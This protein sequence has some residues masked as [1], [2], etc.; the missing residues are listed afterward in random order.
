MTLR[1][2]YHLSFLPLFLGFAA[3]AIGLGYYVV[4]REVAWGLAQESEGYALTLAGFIAHEP[5]TEPALELPRKRNL[6]T[7][8]SHSSGG[9]TVQWF[10][11][12]DTAWSGQML[13][14]TPGLNAP[15]SP[16]GSVLEA[17][18]RGEP[19]AARVRRSDA[20]YD[21]AVGYAP[22]TRADGT[23]RAVIGVTAKDAVT[24]AELR[25]LW[26]SSGWLAAA[27]VLAS[28]VVAEMLTRRAGRDI[29]ALAEGADA[30]AGGDYAHPWRGSIVKE[31]DDLAVTLRAIGRIL[32]D[33]VRQMR[34]HFLR[35]EQLPSDDD[36]ADACE[37]IRA[38]GPAPAGAPQVAV[39]T[40]GAGVPDDFWK[41]HRTDSGWHLVAGRVEAPQPLPPRIER[42]LRAHA[43][44]DLFCGLLKEHSPAEAWR[45]LDSAFTL[46]RGTSSSLL[47]NAELLTVDAERR[48]RMVT[49]GTVDESSLFAVGTLEPGAMRF[50]RDYLKNSRST[51]LTRVADELASL[52]AERG[53]GLLVVF[54]AP[55]C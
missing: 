35:S 19:A 40:I 46:E 7:L 22:L 21:E 2:R 25:S 13:V 53:R 17:L 24:R 4:N 42:T 1:L 12:G 44:A 28:L 47:A 37:A 5:P 16:D 23:L 38:S 8:L 43:A 49:G 45:E 50:A 48:D 27:A 55:R 3:A 52:L 6:A 31:L 41:I 10:E 30:L 26:W 32:G 20:S 33:N 15:P 9:L 36:L 14:A 18:R 34:S 29:D 39:R 11:P 51:D 54:S